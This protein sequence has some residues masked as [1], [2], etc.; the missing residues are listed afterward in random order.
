MLEG[1][2]KYFFGEILGKITRGIP[3]GRIF[4]GI[5]GEIPDGIVEVL[6]NELKCTKKIIKKCLEECL[7]VSLQESLKDSLEKSLKNF[8]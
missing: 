6:H 1:F 4:D 2:L 5:H 7:K 3:A 8:W